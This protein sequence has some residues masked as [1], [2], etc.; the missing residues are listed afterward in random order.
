[1]LVLRISFA[2]YLITTTF[3]SL[4]STYILSQLPVVQHA[5]L[6][7]LRRLFAI[8]VTSIIFSVPITMVSLIGVFVSLVGFSFYTLFKAKRL[9]QPRPLSSLL[10]LN[11][12]D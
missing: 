4:A 8:V 12:D 7:S 5:A 9:R 2:M 3:S 10:P 1:M 6:N 11:T